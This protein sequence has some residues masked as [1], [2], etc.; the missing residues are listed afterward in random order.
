MSD[1]RAEL[2]ALVCLT[3]LLAWNDR[4]HRCRVATCSGLVG[5]PGDG[6]DVWAE[7]GPPREYRGG[8]RAVDIAPRA[9]LERWLGSI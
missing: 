2:V 9:L 6:L 8:G 5:E 4:P 7:G 3:H 1:E